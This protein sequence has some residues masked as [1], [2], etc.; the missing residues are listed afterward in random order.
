MSRSSSLT[1]VPGAVAIVGALAFSIG[2]AACHPKPVR[3]PLLTNATFDLTDQGGRCV[4]SSPQPMHAN[5]G[6]HLVWTIR[7]R[8][9]L[10]YY[11]RLDRFTPAGGGATTIL[12]PGAPET[13]AAIQ[14]GGSVGLPADVLPNA[15]YGKYKYDIQL[16][17]TAPNSVFETRLDP[18]IDIW[19]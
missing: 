2:I 5:R 10:P 18:D 19:P 3:P 13:N 9:A 15:A 8:C 4:P 17:G 16:K 14:P 1:Q 7:N 6:S 11:V 12:R